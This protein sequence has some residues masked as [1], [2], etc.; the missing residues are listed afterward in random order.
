M[1][2]RNLVD[3]QISSA[4]IEYAATEL[5]VPFLDRLTSTYKTALVERARWVIEHFGSHSIPELT[6]LFSSN[7]GRWGSE[8]LFMR[9][10]SEELAVL[11]DGKRDGVST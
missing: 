1:A 4:G 5:T 8:F 7:L 6:A 11:D 2:S 10:F 3:V 9:D